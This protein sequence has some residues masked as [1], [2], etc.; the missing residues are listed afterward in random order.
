[1]FTIHCPLNS[2]M[3]TRRV[4]VI[5]Q[6]SS[7]PLPVLLLAGFELVADLMEA[8][9]GA[10]VVLVFLDLGASATKPLSES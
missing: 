6:N 2:L 9:G 5:S 3:L 4:E 7:S 8:P 10:A 1:M